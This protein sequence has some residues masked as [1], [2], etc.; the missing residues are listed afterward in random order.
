MKYEKPELIKVVVVPGETI[1]L[2]CWRSAP[3][4]C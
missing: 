3:S 2:G 4:S 1:S